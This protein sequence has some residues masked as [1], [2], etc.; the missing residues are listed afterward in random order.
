MT[1]LEILMMDGCTKSE[2]EK[3][4]QNGTVVF[5]S[6]DFEKHFESYMDEWD[7]DD[8]ERAEYRRMI[9]EKKPA[10]DW[11]VVEHNGKTW[12]ISYVL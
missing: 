1:N 12:Y 9:D 8:E 7:I 4:L 5:E 2:A 10:A 3:H 11:G 6:E